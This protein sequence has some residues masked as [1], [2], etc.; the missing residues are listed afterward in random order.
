MTFKD[1]L[2][3]A[4]GSIVMA[5]G[6][7]TAF[8]L[9]AL[10]EA[11]KP[12]SETLTFD[13]SANIPAPPSRSLT[14]RERQWADIAWGY[15]E[16][17]LRPETGLVDSVDGYPG[18][19]MWDAG[20]YL[21]ALISAERLSLITRDTFD[22]R[23]S[24]ALRTL[25]HLSLFDGDA[26]NK[27]YS[28]IT[29]AMVDYQNHETE[30]GIGWSTI[31]IGRM[32]VP[33]HAL[34]WQYPSHTEEVRDLL[35]RWRWSKLTLHGQMIG[36]AVDPTGHTTYVQEG[37]LGYEEYSAK[38]LSLVA[39]VDTQRA[40]QVDD[41]LAFVDAYGIRLA[42]DTRA[43][44][45]YQAHNDIV[46]EPYILDGL[47]FGWDDVSRELA[48]RVEE[49]QE[50]RYRATGVLTAV[51]EDHIDQAPFFVY[52]TVFTNGKLWQA[53]TPEGADASAF[54][55]ISTKAAIGWHALY[56]TDYTKKLVDRI[57][58]LYDPNRGWYAGLYERTSTPNTAIS[59][60]TNAVV[61]ESL[62]F[63]RYGPLTRLD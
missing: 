29:L 31:D 48:W 8:T 16:R 23:V 35:H 6:F 40:R 52:N 9:I 10:L 43:P 37:R 17:N 47:E 3:A 4:R 22:T 58:Q 46:S 19:T 7:A 14:E 28:T 18:T 12:G 26:P 50:A 44:D 15:F 59:C 36:A 20:S 27:A 5:L 11:W 53:V 62:C 39:G 21:M 38:S 34:V 24:R 49:A 63:K 33:L 1:G 61:L 56:E 30:R 25:S 42:T 2:I 41:Y 54:K 60:N 51:S 13:S 57:D 32:L 45:A 55:T